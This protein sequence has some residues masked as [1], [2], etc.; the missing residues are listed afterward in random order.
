MGKTDEA[1]IV[2][3]EEAAKIAN[4]RNQLKTTSQVTIT[5]SEFLTS[6]S[7]SEGSTLSTASAAGGGASNPISLQDRLFN[8]LVLTQ[9]IHFWHTI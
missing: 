3:R 6:E 1:I 2:L 4:Q 5:T 8:A 9:S 7:L